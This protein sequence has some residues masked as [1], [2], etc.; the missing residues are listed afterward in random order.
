MMKK[1]ASL[2][3]CGCLAL[4]GCGVPQGAVPAGAEDAPF[5]ADATAEFPS[6]SS[7]ELL[8]SME[9]DIYSSLIDDLGS[10]E[11]FVENVEAVYVSQEYLDELDFNS[12]ENL[13][14]G[15]K[16]S[17][18]T[19]AFGNEPYVFT[20]GDDGET[21]V[22]PFD[23]Y[24]DTWDKVIGNVAM[25][26][27]VI[28]VCVTVSV[29]TGGA[30][31]PAVSAIFAVSAKTGTLVAL[32]EGAISG[33]IA[34]VV[35]GVQTRDIK[36]SVEASALAASEG[37]KW[38]AIMGAAAGG[39][40]EAVALRGAST[41]GLSYSEAAAI[42]QESKYP[43]DVIKGF[44]TTEQ[45]EICKNAG[46]TVDKVS[47]KAALV[48]EIDLGYT[49]DGVTNLERMLNGRAPLDATGTAYEL[50]HIGQKTD[51]TLAILTRA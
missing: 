10:D 2:L 28:L 14:F 27:G 7:P 36:E 48:R 26:S 11:Y 33:A 20:L 29:V 51:S 34:G 47:N 32:S 39:L 41:N 40:G 37:Y 46:L 17:D 9:G 6:L 8:D 31:L 24:N 5:A 22:A 25:G 13:Y 18:I 49:K 30:G 3:L 38:G 19:E 45:Y 12:Q 15:Y 44:Q 23:P 16:L 50:H 4:Y 43:V 21:Q 1:F 35:T 42:Q